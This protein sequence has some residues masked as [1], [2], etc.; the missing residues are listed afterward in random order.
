MERVTVQS[1]LLT[2]LLKF[3]HHKIHELEIY[4]N[5]LESIIMQEQ[6][7]NNKRTRNW[8]EIGKQTQT[9]EAFGWFSE[10]RAFF[11]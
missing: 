4:R 9:S 8:Q 6:N 3:E 7:Q 10:Y 1:L 2:A 5:L 11:S